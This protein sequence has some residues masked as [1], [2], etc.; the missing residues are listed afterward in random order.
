MSDVVSVVGSGV[1]CVG[2]VSGVSVCSAC[3]GGCS[4]VPGSRSHSTSTCVLGRSCRLAGGEAS[5]GKSSVLV[6]LKSSEKSGQMVLGFSVNVSC[7]SGY[8]LT[9]GVVVG[10]E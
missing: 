6:R 3:S 8:H 1:S 7:P 2:A 5:G 10:S 9:A 4:V